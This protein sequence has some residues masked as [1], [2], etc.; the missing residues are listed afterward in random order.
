MIFTAKMA[1]AGQKPGSPVKE[2]QSHPEVRFVVSQG[3]NSTPSLPDKDPAAMLSPDERA[4]YRKFMKF[5]ARCPCCG[6]PNHD[7]YLQDF[8]FTPR[9]EKVALRDSLIR[10][11]A[12]TTDFDNVY[13]SIKF[14]IGIP[15]CICFKN[16]FSKELLRTFL[17][18][19]H[20]VPN[21]AIFL[22]PFND[23]NQLI[24]HFAETYARGQYYMLDR[25]CRTNG[26]VQRKDCNDYHFFMLGTFHAFY[27][28]MVEGAVYPQEADKIERLLALARHFIEDRLGELLS[29]LVTNDKLLQPVHDAIPGLLHTAGI[30][31]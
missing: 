8:Y 25:N 23:T 17:V 3:M 10:L 5:F 20:G 31:I 16:A 26:I 13:T 7:A 28:V 24:T 14:T 6:R 15:C 11:I 4:T 18:L 2:S 27:V 12:R 30:D 29:R 9:L 21:T 1:P 19:Q 22:H